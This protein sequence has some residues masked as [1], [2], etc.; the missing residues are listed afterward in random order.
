MNQIAPIGDN[1]TPFDEIRDTIE[2]LYEQAEGWLE[3]GPVETQ[4]QADAISKLVGMLQEAQSKADALRTEEVKPFNEGNAAVQERYA[5][6]IAKTKSVTGKTVMAIEACRRA[7]APFLAK[8]QAENEAK[9]TAARKAA[10]DA[11]AKAKAAIQTSKSLGDYERADMVIKAAELAQKVS[12][13][14][15]KAKATATGGNRA[16]GLRTV[17]TAVITDPE[18]FASYCWTNHY[19]E[20][21]EAMQVIADRR[22][23]V[24]KGNLPGVTCKTEQKAQ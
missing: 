20:L 22:V 24:L 15:S 16:M 2:D 19:A 7:C 6:L 11:I 18:Q 21:L 1:R 10:D 8:I 4:G 12:A 3:A 5:P 23:K 9:A 17:Y 14:A 13:V